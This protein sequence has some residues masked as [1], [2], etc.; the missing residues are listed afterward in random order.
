L[1][2]A[3]LANE[4]PTPQTNAKK[5]FR[6]NRAPQLGGKQR[7]RTGHDLVKNRKE[8]ARAAS[9]RIAGGK[10]QGI[11]SRKGGTATGRDP[12]KGTR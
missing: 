3:Y 1:G 7:L 12:A 8:V 11:M 6:G 9:G 5:V 2:K 4:G 10:G